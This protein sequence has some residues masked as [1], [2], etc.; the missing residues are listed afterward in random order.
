MTRRAI[1]SFWKNPGDVRLP[2]TS[3]RGWNL[4]KQ[5]SSRMTNKWN[6]KARL[7]QN[8]NVVAT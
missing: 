2:A 3:A 8:L 5:D 7:E 6:D 1:M 4:N